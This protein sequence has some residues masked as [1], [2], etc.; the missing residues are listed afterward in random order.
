MIKT[1]LENFL[2]QEAP[3]VNTVLLNVFKYD[4]AKWKEVPKQRESFKAAQEYLSLP[5]KTQPEFTNLG[6][7]VLTDFLPKIIELD[8]ELSSHGGL[9]T[10]NFTSTI[11]SVSLLTE[12]FHPLSHALLEAGPV[13]AQWDS[14]T[15]TEQVFFLSKLPLELKKEGFNKIKSPDILIDD[16]ESRLFEQIVIH[17]ALKAMN[18][19]YLGISQLQK[20]LNTFKEITSIYFEAQLLNQKILVPEHNISTEKIKFKI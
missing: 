9:T 20:N 18:M 13:A 2:S 10:Q 15:A 14:Y 5:H 3:Y 16:R 1:S 8:L 6:F 17:E 7:M 4:R 11:Q 12:R 19:G